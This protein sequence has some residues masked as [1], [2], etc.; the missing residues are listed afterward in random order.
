MPHHQKFVLPLS[1]LLFCTSLSAHPTHTK[2]KDRG[3]YVGQLEEQW[4]LPSDHL[5][6]GVI[7]GKERILSWNVLDSAYMDWVMEK[8]SQGLRN[9]VIGKEHVL[10]REKG[11]TLRAQHVANL[12][13]AM[14]YDVFGLQE[15]GTPFIEY[16][17]EILSE[18]Y[19]VAHNGGLAVLIKKEKFTFMTSYSLCGIFY[20]WDK[21]GIQHVIL[22]RKDGTRVRIINAHL[23]GDPSKPTP[24]MFANHL[25]EMKIDEEDIIAL[26]DM[27][28]RES[29]MKKALVS[30]SYTLYSPP[31]CT[32]ISPFTFT[33]KTIDHFIIH[34]DKPVAVLEPEDILPELKELAD[35]LSP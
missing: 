14:E 9:S 10:V 30:T 22:E 20:P 35:L 33:S 6:I 34:S 3:S 17:Q 2:D 18:T 31:Y 27:N 13:C 26:G 29:E 15:V 25:E 23:P 11:L 4:T 12:I 1:F 21:R 32:N 19:Y 24:T 5:P 16:L 28:F 7:H 8:N